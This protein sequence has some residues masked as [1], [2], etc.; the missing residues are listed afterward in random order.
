MDNLNTELSFS[1]LGIDPEIVAALATKNIHYCTSVQEQA[2]PAMLAGRDVIAEAP[3]GTGKTFAFGIPL[4]EKIDPDKQA[5]QGLVL[6]PTREL[7]RQIEDDIFLLTKRLP[8]I[9]SLAIYG[10]ARMKEQINRLRAKPQLII[11]TPGRLI[12]HLKRHNL[13]LEQVSFVV[14]DEADR[15]LDMGFIDDVKYILKQVQSGAQM[16]LFTA[17]LSREVMDI[18]WLYQK[19]AVEIKVAAIAEDKPDIHELYVMANGAERI[20]AIVDLSKKFASQKGL[21]FVNTKQSADITATKLQDQGFRAA[22]LQGD[23]PQSKRNRVMQDFHGCKLDFLVATDVAARGLDVDD[24]DI[25]FNY[26]LPLDLE[27]YTHRIGRTGR[28]GNRGIAVSFVAPGEEAAFDKFCRNLH[29]NPE[30]QAWERPRSET[31]FIS[32][33]L[34]QEVAAR[35]RAQSTYLKEVSA[36]DRYNPHRAGRVNR[37]RRSNSGPSRSQSH[38]RRKQTNNKRQENKGSARKNKAKPQERSNKPQTNSAARR[39]AVTKPK[40]REF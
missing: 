4:I 24:V 12:D 3:T 31:Q 17:T 39:K 36:E 38:K 33:E 30:R 34:E 11:A 6:A 26:D 35:I 32:K 7:V 1:E 27:N 18:S 40:T 16:G 21:I 5:T 20:E 22:S 23:L 25:V 37:A 15:M 14:L 8:E 19:Q 28:A 9:S 29:I 2:I 13:S 10:G